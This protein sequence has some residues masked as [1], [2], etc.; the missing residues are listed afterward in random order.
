M[1]LDEF[2]VPHMHTTI[3]EMLEYLQSTE[4]EYLDRYWRQENVMNNVQNTS[5][6]NIT[7]SYNFLNSFFYQ[8]YGK[9]LMVF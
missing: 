1:D 8:Q 5:N 4:V 6:P 9:R 7:T 3:P 2:I